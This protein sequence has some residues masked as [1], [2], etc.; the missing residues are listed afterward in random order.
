M[1]GLDISERAIRAIKLVKKG[2]KMYLESF[3]QL[4]ITE[5][6]ISDGQIIDNTKFVS[7]ITTLLKKAH[8]KP[9]KDRMVVSVLPESNTFIKVITVPV[10]EEK[11]FP[12]AINEEIE[13]HIPLEIDEIYLDWQPLKKTT[14]AT[15][16]LVGAAPK[17]IVDNYVVALDA[18]GLTISAL[19]IEAAAIIRTLIT[20]ETNGATMLID[21]GAMRTG[22]ALYDHG[23]IQLTVS[24]PISGNRIT[25]TIAQ[26]LNLDWDKAEKAKIVCGLDPQK[27]EG[28]LLKI[29]VENINSLITEIKKTATFYQ[30]NFENPRPVSEII[31]CGGGANFSSID[32]VL[33][34]QLKVAIKIGNPLENVVM[35]NR[36]QIPAKEALSYTTAIGLAIRAAQNKI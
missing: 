18:C 35:R 15:R 34:E 29:L 25:K 27:C 6:I 16:L 26:K 11:K 10:V 1:F 21:F 19:E 22:L 14:S 24:L 3:N 2:K 32:E 23:S 4:A 20:K 13:K 8:G 33:S 30:A 36:A 31:L 5:G 17:Q 12:E 7:A 9:I 28:A